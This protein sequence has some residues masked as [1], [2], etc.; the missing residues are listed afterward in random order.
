MVGW[1]SNAKRICF[2]GLF[3]VTV[4]E[5]YPVVGPLSLSGTA[6]TVKGGVGSGVGANVG[7]GIGVGIGVGVGAGVGGV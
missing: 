6:I 2:A 7:V 3:V 1:P 4:Y 5:K